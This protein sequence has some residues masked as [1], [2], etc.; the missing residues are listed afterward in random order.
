MAATTLWVQSKGLTGT[1]RAGWAASTVQMC[2]VSYRR[3]V[4]GG[5]RRRGCAGSNCSRSARFRIHFTRVTA[6]SEQVLTTHSTGTNYTALYSLV[7]GTF[8]V[9]G[10]V[11]DACN[12]ANNLPFQLFTIFR[13]PTTI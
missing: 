11:D 7:R 2:A 8:A 12:N 4:K 13:T 3:K 6:V 5:E 9:V 10:G 1:D